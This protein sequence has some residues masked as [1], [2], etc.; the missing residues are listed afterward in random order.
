MAL[1]TMRKEDEKGAL[2]QL[3]KEFL[4]GFL[5]FAVAHWMGGRLPALGSEIEP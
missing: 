3:P 2:S 4:A 5:A 1:S